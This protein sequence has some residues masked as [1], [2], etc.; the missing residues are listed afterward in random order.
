MDGKAAAICRRRTWLHSGD[1][2][3]NEGFEGV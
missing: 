2:V 3:G 1:G